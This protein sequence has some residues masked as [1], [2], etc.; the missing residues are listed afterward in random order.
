[1]RNFVVKLDLLLGWLIFSNK[2]LM[3]FA[4]RLPK[5][6]KVKYNI[7]SMFLIIFIAIIFQFFKFHFLIIGLFLSSE[8]VFL[9]FILFRFVK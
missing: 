8:C 9:I 4:N 1:M 7:G 2:T 6:I 3:I 5:S